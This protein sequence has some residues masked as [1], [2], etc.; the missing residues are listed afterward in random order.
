VDFRVEL[1]ESCHAADVI[2]FRRHIRNAP[3]PAE[4]PLCHR[5]RHLHDR[6]VVAVRV[7]ENPDYREL[8][9]AA[10]LE[11]VADLQAESPHYALPDYDCLLSLRGEELT[12]IHLP[13][14]KSKRLRGK[15]PADCRRLFRARCGVENH[16]STG[17]YR[18]DFNPRDSG[19]FFILGVV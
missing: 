2:E 10:N 13:T 8:H 1:V 7:G 16:H 6:V 9:A 3:L 17:K 14:A 4:D 18:N 5:E 19:D 15:N 12:R 11:H